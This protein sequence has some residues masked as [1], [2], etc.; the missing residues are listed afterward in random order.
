LH[1]F[2]KEG[3]EQG[4]GEER[5]LESDFAEVLE[6]LATFV[7]RVLVVGLHKQVAESSGAQQAYLANS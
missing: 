4:L 7:P 3:R 1:V 5:R 2:H 6:V